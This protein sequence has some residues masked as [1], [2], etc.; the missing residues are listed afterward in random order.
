[1]AYS[2]YDEE[3]KH[4]SMRLV[5]LAVEEW[6]KQGL[7][8]S[9]LTLGVPFYGVSRTNGQASTYSEIVDADNR[10][11]TE[12]GRDESADGMWFNNAETLAKKVDFAA[13]KNLGGVMVWELGQD[14]H[15]S[16]PSSGS[17]LR[18]LWDAATSVPGGLASQRR[19]TGLAG[20]LETLPF[21]EREFYVFAAATLGAYMLFLVCTRKPPGHQFARARPPKP[22]RVDGADLAAKLAPGAKEE[23][24]DEPP[25]STKH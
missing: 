9:R 19:P 7:P 2:Q 12:P 11:A 16:N 14:K 25:D 22:G 17:L 8:P 1:M 15:A 10:L 5:E 6:T 4:S 23:D 24:E 21:G 3:K 20:F 18:A 13:S